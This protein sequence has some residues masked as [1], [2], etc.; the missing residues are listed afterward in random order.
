MKVFRSGF[1]FS[2]ILFFGIYQS[3]LAQQF[4]G[5]LT[6][7]LAGSQVAGDTYSGY[8]KAGIV[9]GGFVSLDVSDRSAL[10]MELTYFQKGTRE[11][12][13]EKNNYDFYLFRANYIELPVLY[14]FKTGSQRNFI[15]EAGPSLGFLVGY[16]EEDETEIISD[17]TSNT[18]A[19]ISL[20]INLGIRWLF[21]QH[22]GFSFRIHDSLLN[23]RSENVTGDVWRLW[24]W[25]QFH[26]AIVLSVFYQIR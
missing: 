4:H 6:L 21:T 17:Y 19:R 16:Y 1:L 14:Q 3:A 20:Q 2:L 7:G 18:P 9:A 10:Q 15:I 23:I 5:G 13:T 12:P 24:G 8:K 26:D 25:G 11:N 22:I